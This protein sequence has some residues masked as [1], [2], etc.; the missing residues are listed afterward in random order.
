MAELRNR[1]AGVNVADRFY[2]ALRKNYARVNDPKMSGVRAGMLA[3]WMLFLDRLARPF[4]ASMLRFR[5]NGIKDHK[6]R[7]KVARVAT[8]LALLECHRVLLP[9]IE[10]MFREWKVIHIPFAIVLTI[11]GGIHI[12]I[13]LTR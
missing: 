11:L 4:R 10:P 9:R 2:D 7:T 6:A 1:H 5:L 12:F 13:E 3:M 8:D